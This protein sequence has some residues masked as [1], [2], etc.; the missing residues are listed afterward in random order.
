ML[1]H[2]LVP[3]LTS[4]STS[5]WDPWEGFSRSI[6]QGSGQDPGSSFATLFCRARP[7]RASAPAPASAPGPAPAPASPPPAGSLLGR[8]RSP[9]CNPS[10]VLGSL[11]PQP[12][13]TRPQ[14]P[15]AAQMS[16]RG[17]SGSGSLAGPDRPTRQ[18]ISTAV[19]S[20]T[21]SPASGHPRAGRRAQ[22]GVES[23]PQPISFIPQ[24]HVQ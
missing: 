2:F 17:P 19:P 22:D 8:G 13:P 20:P 4:D 9:R 15:R 6:S 1:P 3:C 10:S 23:V 5:V 16:L 24:I 7:P 11:C 14:L 18:G 21:L 12:T